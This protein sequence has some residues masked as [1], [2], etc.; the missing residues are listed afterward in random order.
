MAGLSFYICC[1][2]FLSAGIIGFLAFWVLPR[3]L[4]IFENFYTPIP[5][6]T[7]RPSTPSGFLG[8][9]GT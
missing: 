4:K 2:F 3:F 7:L 9:T 8:A 1:F 6:P 5:T